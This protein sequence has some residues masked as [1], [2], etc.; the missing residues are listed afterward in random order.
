MSVHE[1]IRRSLVLFVQ[2]LDDQDFDG[3]VELFAPDGRYTSRAGE[4]VGVGRIRN[5]LEAI[6][7]GQPRGW[8]TLHHL[9][10]PVIELIGDSAAEVVTDLIFYDCFDDLPWAV[11]EVGRYRDHMVLIDG[12]WLFAEKRVESDSFVRQSFGRTKTADP[13]PAMRSAGQEVS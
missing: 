8:R 10:S 7:E 11:R 12:R 1:E 13:L 5:H 3:C 9:S 6:Y 4:Q 2:R